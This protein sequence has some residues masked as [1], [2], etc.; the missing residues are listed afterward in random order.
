MG[1]DSTALPPDCN[2]ALGP[3]NYVEFINGRYSVFDKTTAARVQTFTDLT[4]WSRAGISVPSPRWAVTDPRLVYDPLSQR[5]FAVQVDFDTRNL[6]N[7]NHFLLAV[8]GTID[9]TGPWQGFA[10]TSDPTASS[11]AVP[12]PI[13]W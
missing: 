4:F 11:T 6:I 10:I 3:T 2:G 13:P 1:T 7:S 5:W 9:P 12:M 8:S